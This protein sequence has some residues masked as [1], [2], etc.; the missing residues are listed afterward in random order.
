MTRYFR[1][2]NPVAKP[3]RVFAPMGQR[4][5]KCECGRAFMSRKQLTKHM[6]DLGHD[7][8]WRAANEDQ[9]RR[10]DIDRRM[11]YSSEHAHEIG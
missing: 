9:L 1:S 8:G 11:S 6:Y 4:D 5:I 7:S 10:D 3:D 2:K